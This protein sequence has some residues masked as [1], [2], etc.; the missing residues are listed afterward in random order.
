MLH[1]II[2]IIHIDE[3]KQQER[4][5]SQSGTLPAP[6][7]NLVYSPTPKQQEKERKQSS[8]T[9]K[10]PKHNKTKPANQTRSSLTFTISSLAA[11]LFHPSH[12]DI[13]IHPSTHLASVVST[14][15][16][17]D[18]STFSLTHP[19]HCSA[20]KI[21][22]FPS[23]SLYPSHK[24]RPSIHLLL[25]L[26]ISIKS[27]SVLFLLSVYL[28]ELPTQLLRHSSNINWHLGH[29]SSL[30]T[31]QPRKIKPFRLNTPKPDPP[32]LA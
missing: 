31:N 5:D 14:E 32:L 21:L 24:S 3:G 6:A 25:P 20:T 16:P 27:L 8:K 15:Q 13:K 19:P 4:R 30:P 10:Q 17:V 9:P 26:W 12:P 28:Q 22:I 7:M 29:P 1:A 11:C 23:P 18:L 2:I